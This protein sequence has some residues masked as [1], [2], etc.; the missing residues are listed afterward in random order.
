MVNSVANGSHKNRGSGTKGFP[1][2]KLHNLHPTNNE[3][4]TLQGGRLGYTRPA[5]YGSGD[6]GERAV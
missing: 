2:K 5:C 3:I 4:V 6:G 1:E